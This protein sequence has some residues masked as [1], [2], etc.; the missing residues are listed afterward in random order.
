MGAK[1]FRKREREEKKKGKRRSGNIFHQKQFPMKRDTNYN[2]LETIYKKRTFE[3]RFPNGII[4]AGAGILFLSVPRTYAKTAR[5]HTLGA[6]RTR[7]SKN[8]SGLE[9]FYLIYEWPTCQ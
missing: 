3:T 9:N 6:T 7:T 5:E 8:K 2:K 1:L 4:F